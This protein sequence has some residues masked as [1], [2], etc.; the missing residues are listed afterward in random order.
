MAESLGFVPGFLEAKAALG[1]RVN[2]VLATD[3]KQGYAQTD[4]YQDLMQDI[5]LKQLK[6]RHPVNQSLYLW[7]KLTLANYILNT[8]GDGMEMTQSIEGRLPFLDHHL[9]ETVRDMPVS[10]KI[11]GMT[12]K[13]ALREA[14]KPYV[15]ETI[16]NRQKHPFMAP[17]V[18][19]YS[20]TALNGFIQDSI[21]SESFK[22]VPFFDQ[23][24]L[25][26][27]LDNLENQNVKTRTAMEPVLMMVLTTHILHQKFK[28]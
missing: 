16:Y 12:E 24:K 11:K 22:S 20:N 4:C 18:S 13:Y 19:Q 5:D 26:G 27:V 2:S 14:M 6:G 17:P 23:K 9:F 21:R 15:T 1:F 8:L 25:L 7:T 28:L 10:M 3:Y